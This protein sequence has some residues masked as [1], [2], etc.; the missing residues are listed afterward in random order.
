[1]RLQKNQVRKYVEQTAIP[2][3]RNLQKLNDTDREYFIN[4]VEALHE[5]FSG[6]ESQG[7]IRT[8]NIANVYAKTEIIMKNLEHLRE[9][10]LFSMVLAGDTRHSGKGVELSDEFGNKFTWSANSMII[11]AGMF[12]LALCET[13]RDNLVGLIDF[14][15]LETARSVRNPRTPSGVGGAIGTLTDSGLDVSFFDDID[16][17]IRNSFAHFDFEIKL[18]GKQIKIYCENKS[19]KD[20]ITFAELIKMLRWIDR[21]TV[22]LLLVPALL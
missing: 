20:H 18:E 9:L 17:Q 11:Q 4:K 19:G 12:Y 22:A 21:S 7:V 3:V 1:M 10:Y 15:A 5:L 16:N 2:R 14:V 13:I 6:L 8:S